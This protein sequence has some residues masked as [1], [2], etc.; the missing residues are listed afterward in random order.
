M[1]K[2]EILGIII[3]IGLIFSICAVTIGAVNDNN[4]S[5]NNNEQLNLTENT[6]TNISGVKIVNL[7]IKQEVGGVK[8]NFTNN[9][10]VYNITSDSDNPAKVNYTQNGSTLNV[11]I[12]ANKSDTNIEL[13]DK[14]IYNINSDIALED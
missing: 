12:D 14:Y 1:N 6:L 9:S 5:Q 2:Y 8:I 3:I 4:K 10:N 7:N 11:D 13:S